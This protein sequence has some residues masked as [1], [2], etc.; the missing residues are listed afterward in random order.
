MRCIREK[1]NVEE[2]GSYPM[3]VIVWGIPTIVMVCGVAGFHRR[4]LFLSNISLSLSLSL[5]GPIL[6]FRLTFFLALLQPFQGILCLSFVMYS[7]N[8]NIKPM[9]L[10]TN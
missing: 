4:A 9:L 7:C 10:T 6:L 3:H 8:I 2:G 5:S 1:T